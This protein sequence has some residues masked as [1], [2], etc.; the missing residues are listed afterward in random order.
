MNSAGS[1]GGGGSDQ[2]PPHLSPASPAGGGGGG[3]GGGNSPLG[4]VPPPSA[5]SA[6]R[7]GSNTGGQGFATGTP[8]STGGGKKGARPVDPDRLYMPFDSSRLYL[9]LS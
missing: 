1:V 7:L 3:G 2:G 9:L 5:A 8:G 6:S 4:G